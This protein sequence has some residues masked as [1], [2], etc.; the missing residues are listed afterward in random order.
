MYRAKKGDIDDTGT[1]PE[2]QGRTSRKQKEPWLSFLDKFVEENLS[3]TCKKMVA[4]FTQHVNTNSDLAAFNPSM[5]IAKKKIP[6][7]IAKYKK[8]AKK[9]AVG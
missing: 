8:K 4:A 3:L 2:V 9:S 6:A 5:E 1:G 7:M